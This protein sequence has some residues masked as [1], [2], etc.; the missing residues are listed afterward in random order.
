MA[1]RVHTVVQMALSTMLRI[2]VLPSNS[3]LVYKLEGDLTGEW[4]RELREVWFQ[5]PTGTS[6]RNEFVELDGVSRIDAEGLHLLSV[7]HLAGVRFVATA[8]YTRS[9]I[10]E[11]EGSVYERLPLHG[12]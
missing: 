11:F 5:V 10:E 3:L 7:M 2:T 9:L 8:P 4:V 12:G 6:R 1:S